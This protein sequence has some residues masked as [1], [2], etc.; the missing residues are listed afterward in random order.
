MLD[1]KKLK[2]TKPVKPGQEEG[3]DEDEQETGHMMPGTKNLYL[4]V[5]NKLSSA[6]KHQQM[7]S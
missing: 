7:A 5:Q 1:L 4:N 2:L 3:K 6:S